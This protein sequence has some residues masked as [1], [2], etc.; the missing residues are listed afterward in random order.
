MNSKQVSQRARNPIWRRT[1]N[2]GIS[3]VM[4]SYL[5]KSAAAFMIPMAEI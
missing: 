1:M 2:K 5:V 4:H 3:M